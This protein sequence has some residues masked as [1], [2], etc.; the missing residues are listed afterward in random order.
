MTL[1]LCSLLSGGKNYSLAQLTGMGNPAASV[2]AMEPA[3]KRLLAALLGP[4]G[5]EVTCEQGFAVLDAYV[6]HELA[7]ENAPMRGCPECT[8]TSRGARRAP[9]STTASRI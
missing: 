8:R 3:P 4:P 7:S 2:R 1:L 6:E 9:R 5:P